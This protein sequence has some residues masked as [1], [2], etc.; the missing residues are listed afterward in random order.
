MTR[1]TFLITGVAGFIGS[2]TV[3]LLLNN[4]NV[5]GIDNL[6][7]YYDVR[8]KRHRLVNLKKSKNFSFFKTDIEILNELRSIL[9]K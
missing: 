7:D 5:I 6:N 1:N 3:E 8:I 4:S 9:S 2:R